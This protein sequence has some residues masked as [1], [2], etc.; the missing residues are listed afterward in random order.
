GSNFSGTGGVYGVTCCGLGPL[1]SVSRGWFGA[2]TLTLDVAAMTIPD[3]APVGTRVS[4]A[5]PFTMSGF[6]KLSPTTQFYPTPILGDPV[7]SGQVTGTG[8]L[9]VSLFSGQLGSETRWGLTH[10]AN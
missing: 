5:L 6:L 10:P 4:F 7:F 2:T 3:A 1:G 9:N 8:K